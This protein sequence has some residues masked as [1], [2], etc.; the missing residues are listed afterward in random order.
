[1]YY[2]PHG[3][4]YTN[5]CNDQNSVCPKCLR[6]CKENFNFNNFNDK[7]GAN[8]QDQTNTCPLL[9]HFVPK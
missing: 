1:M 7:F 3:K 4:Q 9:S 2:I 6:H 5:Y 8:N